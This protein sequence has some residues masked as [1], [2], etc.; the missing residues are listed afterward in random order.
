MQTC[1]SKSPSNSE[2]ED[3]VVTGSAKRERENTSWSLE[4]EAKL[5]AFLLEHRASMTD[6]QMAKGAIFNDTAMELNKSLVKGAAKTNAG[7]KA[8]WAKV[9]HPFCYC[10]T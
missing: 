4:D 8:K 5:L 10:H 9:C 2:H 6:N 7:V 1:S 3:L